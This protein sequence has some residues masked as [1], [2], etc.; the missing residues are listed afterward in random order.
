MSRVFLPQIPLMRE[1][2]TG[3]WVNKFS[4]TDAEN[5]GTLLPI[6]DSFTTPHDPET[7]IDIIH[8]KLQTFSEKD[9]VLA[10]GNPAILSWTTAI[11]AYYN[12]GQVQMLQ[13]NTPR[14]AYDVIVAQL[15]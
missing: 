4:L 2:D 13:W 3:K 7:V 14:R 8:D 6:L 5:Y 12:D 10:T 1:K 9:F 15:W 11:A